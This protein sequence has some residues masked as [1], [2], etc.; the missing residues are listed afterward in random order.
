[1]GLVGAQHGHPGMV[2]GGQPQ[3][4]WYRNTGRICWQSSQRASNGSAI[5]FARLSDLFSFTSS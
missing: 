1:M 2:Q 5:P 4:G 3:L